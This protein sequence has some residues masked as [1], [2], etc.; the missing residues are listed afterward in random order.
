MSTR[1]DFNRLRARRNESV[2]QSMQKLAD[3]YG[4]PLE[5][6]RSNFNPDACY[7]ACP[8]G[9][10]EHDWTGPEW[11]SEDGCSISSTCARCG[12]TSMSH[13]MRVGP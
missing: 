3:E 11:V 8:D 10:C 7:C 6:M 4:V 2:R 12:T 5:S 1:D 9:P 13:S